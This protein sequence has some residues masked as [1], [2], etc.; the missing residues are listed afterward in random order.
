MILHLQT[1]KKIEVAPLP[2]Y[3][4]FKMDTI[5]LYWGQSYKSFIRLTPG[6]KCVASLCPL[7]LLLGNTNLFI[8]GSITV[9]FI[10]QAGLELAI[11]DIF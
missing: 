4:C 1:Y 8:G 7:S 2:K 11:I 6:L 3:D 10:N 5:V 9:P